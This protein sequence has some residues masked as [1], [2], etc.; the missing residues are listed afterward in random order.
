MTRFL[1]FTTTLTG[2]LT[3]VANVAAASGTITTTTT[4]VWTSDFPDG[5]ATT[6]TY[7]LTE[8]DCNSCIFLVTRIREESRRIKLQEGTALDREGRNAHALDKITEIGGNKNGIDQRYVDQIMATSA[9][10]QTTTDPKTGCMY[11]RGHSCFAFNTL[12]LMADKSVKK[13]GEIAIGDETTYGIVRQS[14]IRRFDQN[15]SGEADFQEVYNGGLY[16]YRG[17]LVTGN[18]AVRERGRWM[19]VADT[20]EAVPAA[21]EK[22][23]HIGNVYNLDIEGGIIPV[24]NPDGE[25]IAFLDGKQPFVLRHLSA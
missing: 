18:H 13:I 2:F 22:T 25:L 16:H 24:I 10:G 19:H 15:R 6:T 4:T 7:T 23:A 12:V 8:E 14:F 9:P 5:P 17:V 1:L 11:I 20:R 3:G 21:A